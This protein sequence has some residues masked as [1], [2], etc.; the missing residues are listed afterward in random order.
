MH[1]SPERLISEAI[2]NTRCWKQG[3]RYQVEQYNPEC[4][5]WITED[6]FLEAE[7]HH[8]CQVIKAEQVIRRS[9]MLLPGD[10]A[11]RRES[12]RG[13]AKLILSGYKGTFKEKLLQWY[14]V[15]EGLESCSAHNA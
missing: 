6:G 14:Q 8:M 9:G 15:Q 12:I 13:R 3:D 4:N 2:A 10:S 11:R 5:I 1:P 7:A